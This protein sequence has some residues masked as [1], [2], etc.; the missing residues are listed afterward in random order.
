MLSKKCA[1]IANL[2]AATRATPLSAAV[3]A[4]KARPNTVRVPLLFHSIDAQR[5]Q[6]SEEEAPES[7]A[8]TPVRQSTMAVGLIHAAPK[9]V[10]E[11]I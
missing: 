11:G 2:T 8:A 3:A 1:S 7:K 9:G 10:I 5:S 4:T 6:S